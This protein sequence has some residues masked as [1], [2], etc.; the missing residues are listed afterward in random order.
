MGFRLLSD[1][2]LEFGDFELPL[3]DTD[4]DDVL[5]LAGDIAV[6][7]NPKTFTR[8]K[9]WAA[10]NRFKKIIH[11]CGNH[12]FYDGSFLRTRYKIREHF[13]GLDNIIPAIDAEA[14]RIDNV[15]YICATLWT[16]F[17]RGNP[18]IMNI[19][20]GALNDYRLIRTGNHPAEPYQRRINGYDTY[21]AHMID[22]N[23]IFD[24]IVKE[25]AAGQKVV[26]VT[27]HGCSRQSIHANYKGDPVNWGY[28]SELDEKI[29][30][31]E[32]DFW[33][34]GHTHHT[35]DYVIGK[36]RVLTNP[37]GYVRKFQ[38]GYTEQPIWIP[39]NSDFNPSFRVEV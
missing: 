31:T 25:K 21:N 36:T 35:F 8:V 24:A 2:H 5:I 26:V 20:R 29:L 17:D 23:F 6:M 38:S 19:V 34:H 12:E 18:V 33:L 39:E 27:H 14:I 15:S 22:R 30:H 13:H 1:L 16:D 9:E 3:L 11:I 28:V 37:R 32:P 4:K 7:A 10:L